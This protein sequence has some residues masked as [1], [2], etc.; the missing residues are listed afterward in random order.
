MVRTCIGR[1]IPVICRDDQQVIVFQ[2]RQEIPEIYIEL[3][4]FFR[5][6][7]GISSV[8]PQCIE[9]YQ[10]DKAQTVEIFLCQLDRLLHAVDRAFRLIRP[11]D[12]LAVEDIPDLSYRDHVQSGIL[13]SVEGGLPNGF[14]A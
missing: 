13:Q 7:L 14:S 12:T 5:I 9:V 2:K 4:D 3:L 11:G 6:A 8:S 1:I 10:I